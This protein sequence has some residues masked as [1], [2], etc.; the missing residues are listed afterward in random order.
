MS[1]PIDARYIIIH[2]RLRTNYGNEHSGVSNSLVL[3]GINLM[4][5]PGSS[6]VWTELSA[7]LSVDHVP[8]KMK[9]TKVTTSSW[10]RIDLIHSFD[11]D[12][13]VDCDDEYWDHRDPEKRFKQPPNTPSSV[14]AFISYIKLQQ[15]LALSLRTI[16]SDLFPTT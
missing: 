5:C 1:V 2:L 6:C 7:P 9:S 15:V 3:C 4:R 13:P 12:L 16:V 14:T 11:L 10:N 8:S